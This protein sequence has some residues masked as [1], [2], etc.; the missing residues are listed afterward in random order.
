MPIKPE[1]RRLYPEDWPDISRRIRFE[2]AGGVCQGC[3]RP[4]SQIIRCL[5]D[6]RWYDAT[7]RT[8]RSGR[9]RD[10]RWP[11][12]EEITRLRQ[13]RVILAAAHLDHNPRNN[14]RRNLKSLCQRCHLIHDRPTIWRSGGLPICSAA[15]SATSFLVLTLSDRRP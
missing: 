13:T 3:G 12:L 5:P 10:S 8:W 6:G 15:L 7:R 4:H 14:R 1:M 9:G 11:D 2:R